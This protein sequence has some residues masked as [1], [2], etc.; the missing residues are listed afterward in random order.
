MPNRNCKYK[1]SRILRLFFAFL[2]IM[3]GDPLSDRI[4]QRRIGADVCTPG[5]GKR[6][7]KRWRFLALGDEQFKKVRLEREQ[8]LG[9]PLDLGRVVFVLKQ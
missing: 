5:E 2:P 4:L 9:D 8:F 1:N 3:I 6:L 7:L